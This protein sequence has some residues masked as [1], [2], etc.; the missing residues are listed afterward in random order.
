M[1][2][3]L[4]AFALLVLFA[5]SVATAGKV[6]FISAGAPDPRDELA[7]EHLEKL[8]LTVEA[9][10]ETNPHPVNLDGVD[11][12]F[13]SESITSSSIGDVYLD[14]TVPVV[15]CEAWAYD[16]MGF[17]AGDA[18]L[19]N[20]NGDT[21]TIVNL[22]HPITQ[23]FPEEVKVY[24]IVDKILSAKMQ[25]DV[26]VLAVRPDDPLHATIS[27]Y[28]K[29]A[30]TLTG[31]TKARHINLFSHVGWT[32]VT[33]D[34]WELIER[35]VLYALGELLAVKPVSKLAVTWADIKTRD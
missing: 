34:G 15:N 6:V 33:D 27:V 19:G 14:S 31:E 29:G 5:G 23:G 26:E 30:K 20:A 16:D 4:I 17:A 1:Y 13:I 7:I 9:Y 35:S 24:N 8:G 21:L 32:S 2:R 25:G 18:D 3:M 22:D 11:L 10:I 12:I 28:E